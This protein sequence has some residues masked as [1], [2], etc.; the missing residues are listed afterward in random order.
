L[1]TDHERRF[2]SMRQLG[3]IYMVAVAIGAG[4]MTGLVSVAVA[5]SVMAML[6][7]R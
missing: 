3:Y 7:S 2:K 6:I 5:S 4:L 1:K